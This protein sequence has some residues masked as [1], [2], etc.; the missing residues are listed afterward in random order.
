[1][2]KLLF[3][4]VF[5]FSTTSFIGCT[6]LADEIEENQIEEQQLTPGTDPDDDGTIDPDPEETGSEE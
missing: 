1:M 3:I 6:N 4:I 2:K 5:I